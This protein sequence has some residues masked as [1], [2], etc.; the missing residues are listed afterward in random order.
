[1]T[2]VRSSDGVE[3]VALWLGAPGR[4]HFSWLDFPD[5]RRVVGAVVV[6]PTMGMEADYSARALRDLA[7]R[8]A[9]SRWLAIRV[10]YAGMGDSAGSWTDP[11]LVAEWRRSIREAIDYAR[12]LGVARVAVVGLRVGATLAGAELAA[13]GGVDE[14]V[15]WDP[16]ATGKSFFR[17]QRAL[18][19][20]LRS[21][22]IAW[23]VLGED[24]VWGSG[25]ETDSGLFEAP[26]VM[27]SASTVHDLEPLA[28]VPG[29][30]DLARRELIL[31]REG[32]K[33]PT[34]L[35][36]RASLPGVEFVEVSGQESLLEVSAIT[37]EPTLE[38]IVSWLTAAQ[39]AV[40]PIELPHEHAPA[41]HRA[42]DGPGIVERPLAIGPLGLFGMLSEPEDPV[43][44]P[45]PTALFFNAGR[46]GHQGP[47]RVWVDL[48]RAC[49]ADGV[50]CLRVDLSG[51]GES[52]TRP[53]RTEGVEFPADGLEDVAQI[54]RDITTAFGPQI[55]V[56]G[57]CSGGHY[58]VQ[59]ALAD[60]VV[61][62]CV[63]NPA[64]SIY[65][66]DS[67]PERRF[68]PNEEVAIPDSGSAHP[69]VSKT[70]AK[71]APLRDAARKSPV[72]WWV[73]KRFFVKVSPGQIFERL[74]QS[75]AQVL[76]VVGGTEH[77]RLR[78]GEQRRFRSLARQGSFSLEVFPDLEHSLLERTGRERVFGIMHEFL[79]RGGAGG[80]AA[81]AGQIG[82]RLSDPAGV[83]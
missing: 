33:V 63:V 48:A 39:A 8:L 20:F 30:R 53:G 19:A 27:F 80:T 69:L 9:A 83:D 82:G 62:V 78:E 24:Q 73:L 76:V 75:G 5:D 44:A 67:R 57:L 54:R 15:L 34:A 38:R 43:E 66:W 22:A 37:P 16:C 64:L 1:M 10:D 36:E 6:C 74:T 70:M 79:V 46:I 35:S 56:V 4:P 60:P 77:R 81:A 29:D 55:Q 68:E 11:D 28:I 23:G 40:V 41:V 25:Q 3:S 58:A 12:G 2:E 13:G 59:S 42:M 71:L 50:R 47:A 61:T 49:A 52:P 45:A 21:Q 18:W 7:R 26:G 31:A 14:L 72:G 17:E 32:R 51:L 65:P